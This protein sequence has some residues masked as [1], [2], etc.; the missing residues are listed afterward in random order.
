[1]KRVSSSVNESKQLEN[2]N[3]PKEST[4]QKTLNDKKFKIDENHCSDDNVIRLNE[5]LDKRSLCEYQVTT[6][7][8]YR[9]LTCV[10]RDVL[11]GQS[12]M[13]VKTC[14]NY[15]YTLLVLRWIYYA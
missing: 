2:C 6:L 1:M 5:C 14:Q 11:I 4:Y 10:R 7:L 8:S 12:F 9:L 15:F 13:A 3:L